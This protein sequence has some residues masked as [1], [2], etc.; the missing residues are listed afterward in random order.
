MS[1]FIFGTEH[2]DKFTLIV[3]Y[4]LPLIAHTTTN[5]DSK[6]I[7]Q[8]PM[9]EKHSN[10]TIQLFSVMIIHYYLNVN[11]IT[12]HYSVNVVVLHY[13]GRNSCLV[14]KLVAIRDMMLFQFGLYVCINK[15]TFSSSSI[16]HY[17]GTNS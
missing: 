6:R 9:Q 12:I 8:L 4:T 14:T 10:V 15:L 17:L 16:L 2:I 13:V 1:R 5:K 11:V 3:I 7:C